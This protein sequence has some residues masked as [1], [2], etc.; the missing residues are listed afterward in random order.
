MNPNLLSNKELEN[1]EVEDSFDFLI[2]ADA[3]KIFLE[4]NSSKLDNNKM[5]VLYGDWGSGKTSLMRHIEKK[6]DQKIYYPIFFQAWQ[7][8]KDENLALSLCD[9]LTSSIEGNEAI[10]KDFMKGAFFSAKKLCKR[11]N[12]EGTWIFDGVGFRLRN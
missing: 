2:K 8:E 5:I 4:Q 9:A 3:I 7:H 11:Y 6:I 1:Y 12:I 10:I